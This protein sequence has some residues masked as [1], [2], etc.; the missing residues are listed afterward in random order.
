MSRIVITGYMIRHPLAGNLFAFFHYILGLHRLGHD[1]VYLEESGWSKSCYNPIKWDYGDDPQTGLRFVQALFQDYDV[2]ARICYVNRKTG[3]TYGATWEDIKQILSTADILLNIG[4]VC[5]LSEFLLCKRRSLIDMDPF[6]TQIGQFGVEGRNHYHAYFS[7]G[8]NIGHPDCTIPVE[9]INWFPTI[10]PVVPEIWQIP[11]SSP[12]DRQIIERK[13]TT[14]TTIANW[15][16]YGAVT[17]HDELY[18]Q[19]DVEFLRLIELPKLTSQRLELALSGASAEIWNCME[20][21]GWLLREGSDISINVPTY[22]SYIIGSRGEFSVAKNAYVKS[23]SGWFSDRSVCYLAAG[24]PVVLQ[25]T[26]FSNWLS[27]GRGV[28]GFSSLKEAAAGIEEVNSD[29]ITHSRAAR[30][31]AEEV[32]SYRVV[33][34]R[35]IDVIFST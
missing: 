24:R 9:N 28:I 1:V 7:Y 13:G 14:F 17:Y 2:K 15:S 8:T 5:W 19:K 30:K 12:E 26:G 20:M 29:Y 25:D 31:I 10:P 33:L 21:K 34:P 18:S 32:F 16:G 11:P 4:G 27:S 23:R 6:F 3:K 35:L 22:R